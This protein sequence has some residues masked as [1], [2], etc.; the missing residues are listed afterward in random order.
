MLSLNLLSTPNTAYGAA[1]AVAKVV[2]SNKI[3]GATSCCFV[4]SSKRK[5]SDVVVSSL[6]NLPPTTDTNARAETVLVS[7]D[8][9]VNL[10]AS[11]T[12][13]PVPPL[14]TR[15]SLILPEDISEIS[16]LALPLPIVAS[17][18]IDSFLL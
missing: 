17:K 5:F 9:L 15:T 4:P 1:A 6:D 18:L 3:E 7:T 12:L 10:I 8:A 2:P 13:Y 14:S 16:A 11:P